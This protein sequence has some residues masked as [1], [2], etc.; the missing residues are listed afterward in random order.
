[1]YVAVLQKYFIIVF[2]LLYHFLIDEEKIK[3]F[4]NTCWSYLLYLDACGN[5]SNVFIKSK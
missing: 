4:F 5:A 2:T 3:N 1:M